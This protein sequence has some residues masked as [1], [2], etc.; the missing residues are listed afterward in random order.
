MLALCI[1]IAV[2]GLVMIILS[3]GLL[4]KGVMSI[5]SAS[6]EEA[7]SLEVAEKFKIKTRYPA[8]GLF[9]LGS[10]L[11]IGGALVYE[12]E[13]TITVPLKG[14][15]IINN[16]ITDT[17]IRLSTKPMESDVPTDGKINETRTIDLE[18]FWVVISAPGYIQQTR[19]ITKDDIENNIPLGDIILELKIKEKE[20]SPD[21]KEEIDSKTE[22]KLP[23][24][25]ERNDF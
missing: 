22:E 3:F 24:L 4:Y 17:Q 25:E 6:Q 15:L 10:I 21:L 5:T 11:L 14:R 23:P 1:I 20:S 19:T 18:N 9:I 2:A 7:L 13:R 12:K 16:T 8:L